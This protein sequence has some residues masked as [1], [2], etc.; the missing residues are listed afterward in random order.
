MKNTIRRSLHTTIVL[1]TSTASVLLCV[2]C[3]ES[4]IDSEYR[5]VKT[6]KLILENEDGKSYEI[7]VD[8][9]GNLQATPLGTDSE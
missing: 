1:A 2:A 4:T 3:G 9:K 8:K 6:R 5:T 7:H